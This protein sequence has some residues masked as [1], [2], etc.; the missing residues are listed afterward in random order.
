MSFVTRDGKTFYPA[1]RTGFI[2]PDEKFYNYQKVLEETRPKLE[3]LWEFL[4]KDFPDMQ[5]MNVYGE[6]FGGDYPHPEVPKDK[7]AI[8]I[9]KGI[10]YSPSNH[11][12]AFD[13]LLDNERYLDVD[14]ANKYFEKAGLLHAKTLFRGSL[15]DCLRYPNDFDSKVAEQLGLPEIKPNMVE[16]V[17]I[18]PVQPRFFNNGVRVILK[19]K[20]EKWAENKM[21]RKSR[22]KKEEVPPS[23]KVLEL[24]E[25]IK[26]Y[27]TE[28]RL[29]NVI[30]KIGEVSQKD[31][32]KLM[33]MFNKDVVEDFTKDYAD[34]LK[35]LDKKE[36]KLINKSIGD[37]SRELIKKKL[38]NL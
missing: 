9:Q 2:E 6:M 38:A 29:N 12:Y 13:I 30:S 32:G 8:M 22:K 24:Q 36:I 16:G 11:F 18:K 25:A 31:F 23:E 14:T 19:N 1:K 5:Q 15:D 34:E 33:G 17:V 35:D 3:K 37:I 4:K 10:Y 28:N 7:D 20:N 21:F 26:S 27:V